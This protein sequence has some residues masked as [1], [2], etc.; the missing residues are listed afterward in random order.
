MINELLFGAQS[1]IVAGISI[2]A[3]AFGKEALI[4]A[5]AIQ[6]LIANIFV[7]KQTTF[8]GLNATCADAFTIGATLCINALRE[9]YG[10]SAARMAVRVNFVFLVFYT[11]C[12]II[13]VAYIPSSFDTTQEHFLPLLTPM[14]RLVIASFLVYYLSQTIDYLLYG[15]LKQLIGNRFLFF[16]NVISA[17]IS[18]FIDTVLFTFLGLYGLIDNLGQVIV[19]SYAIKIALI[20]IIAPFMAVS[21]A[22]LRWIGI[23]VPTVPIVSSDKPE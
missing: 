9:I 13:H 8:F 12:S 11:L 20:F 1:I 16:R 14:P 6:C 2:I 18:Q 7:L 23:S 19:V 5:V 10:M 21:I 4:A 3:L 15:K 17:G 22:F